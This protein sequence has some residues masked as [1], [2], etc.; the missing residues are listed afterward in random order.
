MSR[1]TVTLL[2]EIIFLDPILTISPV[3]LAV[4]EVN[5]SEHLTT[6]RLYRFAALSSPL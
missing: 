4:L 5:A 6:M 2:D 3:Q 1:S